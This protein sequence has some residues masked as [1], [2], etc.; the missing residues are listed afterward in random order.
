MKHQSQLKIDKSQAAPRG[1]NE[2]QTESWGRLGPRNQSYGKGPF[3]WSV[4][5]GGVICL[6]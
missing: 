2:T 6:L 4:G 5:S 3:I 1:E